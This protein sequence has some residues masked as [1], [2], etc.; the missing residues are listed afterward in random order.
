MQFKQ[1]LV[2]F[3]DLRKQI[4][5]KEI[6]SL[7]GRTLYMKCL[8]QDEAHY[9]SFTF[10]CWR[11]IGFTNNGSL[12]KQYRWTIRHVIQICSRLN[13][14]LFGLFS[15]ITIVICSGGFRTNALNL[16]IYNHEHVENRE[17]RK[18]TNCEISL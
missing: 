9:L 3:L 6:T 13:I 4:R 5:G 1:S 8:V 16:A 10:V 14:Y 17:G 2:S 12:S 11:L 18:K 15:L 7:D